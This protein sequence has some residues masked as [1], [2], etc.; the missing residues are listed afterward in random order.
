MQRSIY[1]LWC[2]GGGGGGGLNRPFILVL[3]VCVCAGL[4]NRPFILGRV[5]VGRGGGG[6]SRLR[7]NTR[8]VCMQIYLQQS[9]LTCG[10][11]RRNAFIKLRTVLIIYVLH[12]KIFL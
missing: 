7:L 10:R 5:C 9:Q 8:C 6:A 1:D 2:V 11:I 3:C 12:G 4:V